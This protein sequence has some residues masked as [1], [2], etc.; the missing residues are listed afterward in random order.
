M[1]TYRV[2]LLRQLTQSEY[3]LVEADSEEDAITI[4]K[5]PTVTPVAVDLENET[6]SDE[7]A[8]EL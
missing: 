8:E 6:I 7:E 3:Y 2:T 5:D 1:P 4:A